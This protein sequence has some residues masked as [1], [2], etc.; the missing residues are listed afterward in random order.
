MEID[1]L[2]TAAKMEHLPFEV[3]WPTERGLQLFPEVKAL[4]ERAEALENT[5]HADAR[6]P[7]GR[8]VIATLPS[9]G[10][11]LVG[12]LFSELRA[13]HPAV[14]LKV[15]EGSSGQVEEWLT[16]E[17]ADLAILY[18]YGPTLPDLEQALKA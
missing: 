10:T 1:D 6:E 7:V 17:R 9:I 14:S 2:G 11:I 16:D 18:R 8:V 15:L 12:R 4:L 13:R 5:I 3:R